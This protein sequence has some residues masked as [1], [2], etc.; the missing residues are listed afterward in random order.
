MTETA[1]FKVYPEVLK[2]I[3]GAETELI[4]IAPFIKIDALKRILEKVSKGVKV[5][6]IA[7]WRLFDLLS[8]ISDMEVYA[9]LKDLDHKFLINNNIHLKIISKDKKE[10]LIG[11]ANITESGLGFSKNTNI[12]AVMIDL[13]DEEENFCISKILKTS[14]EVNDELFNKIAEEISSN[15]N[16]NN[17]YLKI[18]KKIK[19]LDKKLN[20]FSAKTLIVNDFP[21]TS[22]P[23]E[24]IDRYNKRD[25]NSEIKHDINLFGLKLNLSESAAIKDLKLS[26]LRCDSFNW[27]LE[28]IKKETLF[29][30]YTELLHNS[31]VDDPRPYRKRVKELANNM[32]NWTSEFSKEFSFKR[33]KHTSAIIR[34]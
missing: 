5:V 34:N 17:E 3:S 20:Y 31:L 24:F 12:E 21:F 6:V 8:G 29:G 10:L 14:V 19:N 25:Y 2:F 7:R 16:I 1:F 15:K 30:E 32:F 23:R 4:I 26:F 9:Y 18:S 33:Y 22:S 27:E 28:N 13:L 11:S